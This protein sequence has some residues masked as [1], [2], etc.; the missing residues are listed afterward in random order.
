MFRYFFLSLFSLSLVF[1]NFQADA[2][3]DD[4]LIYFKA[5]LASDMYSA[6]REVADLRG[7]FAITLDNGIK[8]K[9]IQPT[10]AKKVTLPISSKISTSGITLKRNGKCY[11]FTCANPKLC[12]LVWFDKNRDGKVQPRRELRCVDRNGK[13]CQMVVKLVQCK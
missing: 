7:D 3:V 10:Y 13:Q 12:S 1:S 4:T 5:P 2:Q 9:P 6:P 8:F 11:R